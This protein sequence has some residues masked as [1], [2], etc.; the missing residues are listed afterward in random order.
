MNLSFGNFEEF[1]RIRLGQGTVL[2]QPEP[3]NVYSNAECIA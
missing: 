2:F 1:G 3:I